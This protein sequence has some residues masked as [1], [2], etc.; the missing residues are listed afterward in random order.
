LQKIGDSAFAVCESLTSI[1]LP[2]KLTEIGKH[3]FNNSGLIE[4]TIPESVTK[5]GEM[6]FVG[7]SDL[8]TVTINANI[9][10]LPTDIFY[11]CKK[12]TNVTLPDSLK[13]IDSLAIANTGL[14][15]ITIPSNVTKID[16][17]AFAYN[18]KLEK[19]NLPDGLTTIDVM[20]F[21]DCKSLREITLPASLTSI[22]EGAFANTAFNSL[23]ITYKGTAEQWAAIKVV[24]DI[25]VDDGQIVVDKQDVTIMNVTLKTNTAFLFMYCA[26]KVECEVSGVYTI[27][28]MMKELLSDWEDS[29]D[30]P[31][32]IISP[33]YCFI[34]VSGGTYSGN[35]P[36]IVTCTKG[37][38]SVD[39]DTI[40]I[41]KC[42]KTKEN[43]VYSVTSDGTSAKYNG[44]TEHYD[45]IVTTDETTTTY[46][47]NTDK[48]N[49]VVTTEKNGD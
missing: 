1:T 4:I 40:I 2:S 3:A 14:V 47:W 24:G 49:Y 21:Y 35:A 16:F 38:E 20:A 37:T 10:T 32:G 18:N 34:E 31:D 43:T 11:D 39:D 25:N 6:T 30:M 48:K 28:D 12:L 41:Y 13:E 23:N 15:E 42:T 33:F 22:G 46:A 8:V 44:E 29:K 36:V 27:D 45:Y 7:C 19:V 5:L 26:T 9:E 17:A